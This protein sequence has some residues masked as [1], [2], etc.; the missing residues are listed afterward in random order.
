MAYETF[1]QEYEKATYLFYEAQ[2]DSRLGR[3]S[4]AK[5]KLRQV[6]SELKDCTDA[7]AISLSAKARELLSKL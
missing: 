6:E 3:I 7:G 2:A 4:L 1:T 5:D